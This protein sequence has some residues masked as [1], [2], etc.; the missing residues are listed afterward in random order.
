MKC[1]FICLLTTIAS[2]LRRG[3][4]GNPYVPDAGWTY[5]LEASR[6]QPWPACQYR[7]LSLSE[8]C[9][10]VDLW[11]AAGMDRNNDRLPTKKLIYYIICRAS[12]LRC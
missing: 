5:Y 6:Q 2:I 9:D 1:F 7:F 12:Y 11:K 8:D 10:T 3:A 4:N